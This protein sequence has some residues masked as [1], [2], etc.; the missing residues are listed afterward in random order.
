M[1][2]DDPLILGKVKFLMLVDLL[3]EKF[4]QNFV[5]VRIE[6]H[7]V[8]LPDANQRHEKIGQ[9]N[10]LGVLLIEEKWHNRNAIG[11]LESI[12][13]A[14]VVDD[15]YVLN[16]P[17][18]EYAE[19]FHKN[20]FLSFDAGVSEHSVSDKLVVRIE[21]VQNHIRVAAM[22]GREHDYFKKLTH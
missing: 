10:Q 17:V 18:G 11:D 1:R 21:K 13:V 15:D 16:I 3:T 12:A 8:L 6:I 4:L 7:E 22:G 5:D 20:T 2:F 19:I 9:L 14:S